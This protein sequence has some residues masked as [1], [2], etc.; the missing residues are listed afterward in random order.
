MGQVGVG[1]RLRD[2][3]EGAGGQEVL[4]GMQCSP[5]RCEANLV[6][7]TVPYGRTTYPTVLVLYLTPP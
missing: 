1:G 4:T 7:S 6:K 3:H 5:I 2:L